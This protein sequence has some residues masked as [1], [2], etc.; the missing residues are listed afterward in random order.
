MKDMLF[1]DVESCKEKILED[2]QLIKIKTPS[3]KWISV[4]MESQ[5]DDGELLAILRFLR[6]KEIDYYFRSENEFLPM[7]RNK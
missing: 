4:D 7:I 5:V 2:A 6:E 1:H 3:K